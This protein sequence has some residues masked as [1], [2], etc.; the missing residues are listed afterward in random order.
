MKKHIFIICLICS[1]LISAQKEEVTPSY[2]FT[3]KTR[4]YRILPDSIYSII[5]GKPIIYYSNN[6]NKYEESGNNW[7]LITS[8]DN[9]WHVYN[10]NSSSFPRRIKRLLFDP[11][12]S[13]AFFSANRALFEWG[14]DT[15]AIN[16]QKMKPIKPMVETSTRDTIT[17][18][19]Y[20]DKGAHSTHGATAFSGP[21]SAE[22]NAKL[23]K[24]ILTMCWLSDDDIRKQLPDSLMH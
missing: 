23:H 14:L 20:W 1:F 7:S 19:K 15:L 2:D 4:L 5:E 17:V 11:A 24:L 18:I 21:D 13:A 3:L 6:G 8:I 22:F 9:K 16:L 12:D 10:Y